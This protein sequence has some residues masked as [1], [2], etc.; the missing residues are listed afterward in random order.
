MTKESPKIVLLVPFSSNDPSRQRIWGHTHSWLKQTLDYPM[1]IGEQHPKVPAEYNLSLARN[2]AS[3]KAG[4]WDVAIFNDADTVIN[5]DQIKNGVK[6]AWETGAVVYPYV[7]R[8]ELDFI[9]TEMLLDN[10][11]SDWQSHLNKYTTSQP[12]GGCIIV[13]RDMWELVRGFDSGFVG[14]GHE[15]GAFAIASEVLSG[16][17]IKRI[18]GKSLHLEHTKAPAKNPENPLY[19]ANRKRIEEYIYAKNYAKDAK[20]EIREFRNQSIKTDAKSGIVWQKSSNKAT[21]SWDSE[22]ALILLTDITNVLEKYGCTHWLA[23]GTLMGAIYYNG[24]L[25]ND[26]DIDLGVWADTFDIRVIHELLKIYDCTV[27]RLQGKPDDGMI[28]TVSRADVHLDMF[29]FYPVKTLTKKAKNIP[30]YVKEVSSFYQLVK[31]YNTSNKA[32]KYDYGFLSHKP[33]IKHQFL[34]K[35]YWVPKNAKAQLELVYGPFTKTPK[36][37]WDTAKDQLN[38]VH[39]TRINDMQSMQNNLIAYLKVNK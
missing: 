13:R 29:F 36:S 33:L 15:D 11:H 20:K 25:P 24:F 7:E 8:W 10:E 9:G 6:L 22:T 21:E 19:I 27:N 39:L 26:D 3:Q 37:G 2:D 31:P 32:D 30:K 17:K 18:Q 1:F 4:D 35:E 34:N 5:P 14:W 16:K 28:I 12:L 23:Y 38:Q